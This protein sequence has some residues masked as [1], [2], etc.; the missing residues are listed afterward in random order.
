M[1]VR[2]WLVGLAHGWLLIAGGARAQ[3]QEGTATCSSGF[4][5]LCYGDHAVCSLS[6]PSEI[7]LYRF[8]GAAGDILRIALAGLS[9]DLDP[10]Y[11]LLDPSGVSLTSG[12]CS[13]SCCTTCSTGQNFTLPASGTYTILISDSGANNT[14]SYSLNIER[15]LPS[16]PYRFAQYGVPLTVT[17]GHAA[18]HDFVAIEGRRDDLVRIS[19]SGLSNDLDPVYVLYDPSGGV[20]DSGSCSTSCCTTCSIV[21]PILTLPD[22]GRY[23]V[24]LYDSGYNNTGSISLTVTCVLGICPPGLTQLG[25]NYCTTNP[26]STGASAVM[27]AWGSQDAADE[28]LFLYASKLPR[29]TVGIFFFGG[30]TASVPLGNGVRCVGL[31]VYRFAPVMSC[32]RGELRYEVDFNSLPGGQQFVPGTTA[33]FQA[34]FRDGAGTT[35]TSDGLTISFL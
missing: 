29:N 12:A 25:T 11:E 31:P 1:R 3:E 24:L 30:T 13:T 32:N 8:Q 7:D 16:I 35:N 26:N 33:H 15:I 2:T 34:W 10:R 9:N 6:A 20:V 28:T 27:R 23:Y 22:D 19:V 4:V 21:S 17:I 14:G 18:D 5:P